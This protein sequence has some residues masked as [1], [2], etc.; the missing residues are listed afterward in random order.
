MFQ[1]LN[2]L[3]SDFLKLPTIVSI[4]YQS[5][6][7]LYSLLLAEYTSLK[8]ICPGTLLNFPFFTIF[9]AVHVNPLEVIRLLHMTGANNEI[10]QIWQFYPSGGCVRIIG[11][12]P[13]HHRGM[14]WDK[15]GFSS[16]HHRGMCLDNWVFQCTS[17]GHV[18][19]LLY[20]SFSVYHG[21][22]CLDNSVAFSVYIMCWDNSIAF[23]NVHRWFYLECTLQ[24]HVLGLPMIGNIHMSLLV[25]TSI[26]ILGT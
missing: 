4:L 24:G 2:S 1:L 15:C 3:P 8:N 21:G 9:H 5:P 20:G 7:D 10:T 25:F 6:V 16:V 18:L 23:F 17:Q 14:C 13:V 12:S 11:F 26:S 22:M 19:G